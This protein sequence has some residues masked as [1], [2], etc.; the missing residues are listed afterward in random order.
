MAFSLVLRFIL[1]LVGRPSPS[2]HPSRVWGVAGYRSFVLLSNRVCSFIFFFLFGNASRICAGNRSERAASDWSNLDGRF[3][4]DGST[5]S[6][7]VFP[8][9]EPKNSDAGHFHFDHAGSKFS[10]RLLLLFRRSLLSTI[11]SVT[12]LV[13]PLRIPSWVSRSS[14]TL[15]L[16]HD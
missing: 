13:T 3:G 4:T 12:Y 11:N 1:L 9:F 6:V 16:V 5:N 7:S 14:I 15:V 8:E 2:V 10:V